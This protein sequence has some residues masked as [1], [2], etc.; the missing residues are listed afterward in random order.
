MLENFECNEFGTTPDDCD[1]FAMVGD[2]SFGE[3]NSPALEGGTH[4]VSFGRSL[5]E[6]LN[7][8]DGLRHDIHE[9]HAQY[10]RE[11]EGKPDRYTVMRENFERDFDAYSRR[12]MEMTPEELHR[13]ESRIQNDL[14]RIEANA[15]HRKVEQ[16][17]Y[18][19]LERQTLDLGP[20]EYDAMKAGYQQVFPKSSYSLYS[21]DPDLY[22]KDGH[23]YKMIDGCLYEIS[24]Y[25][26][27]ANSP[28]LVTSVGGVCNV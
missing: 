1:A 6:T 13:E 21:G 23:D 12:V 4:A 7:E 10:V 5:E 22:T 24:E 17:Y 3:T 2:V 18:D 20:A 8:I 9:L 16:Q 14:E 11:M 15:H 25:G 26:T 27:I 28:S 19:N